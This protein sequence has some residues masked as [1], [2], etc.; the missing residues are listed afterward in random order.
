MSDWHTS[1]GLNISTV[2][3]R[4]SFYGVSGVPHVRIDGLYSVVGAGSCVSA[5]AEYRSRVNSRLSATGGMA[6]V[7]IEGYHSIG[8]TTLTMSV[9]ATLD[10]AVT[11]QSPRMYLVILEDNVLHQGVTYQHIVR[12]EYHEDITLPAQGSVDTITHDFTLGAGWN[13]HNLEC[14]A[15]VQKMTGDKEMYNAARIPMP[16]DFEFALEAPLVSVPQ[17]NGT[18][19]FTG[20][21]TNVSAESDQLTLSLDNTFNW[22]A[23]FMVEGEAGYHTTPSVVDLDSEEGVLVHVRVQT[24]AE[25]RIGQANLVI[26]SSLTDRTQYALLRVFNGSPAILLVDDDNG[27]QPTH[28]TFIDGLNAAGYLYDTWD[29][30]NLHANIT[31]MTEEMAPYDLV[32]WITGWETYEPI[33]AADAVKIMGYMDLGKGFIISGQDLLSSFTAGNTFLVDYLGIGTFTTQIGATQANGVAGDP[34]SAGLGLTLQYPSQSINRADEVIANAIGTTIFTNQTGRPVAVRADNGTARS[35]TLAFAGTAIVANPNPNNCATLLDRSIEWIMAGQGQGVEEHPIALASHIGGINP[36]PLSFR[37]GHGEAAIQLRLSEQAMRS[38]VR[39][40]ILDL[41]GRLVSNVLNG[42][43]P[44]G[45][46]AAAW[47]GLDAS[48]RPVGSGVY[49]ARLTTSDGTHS[50]RMVITR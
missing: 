11:L 1:G 39:V 45:Q 23:E 12:A 22:P 35:V 37:G 6:P 46:T 5:A 4:T 44:S 38:P 41:N 20:Q 40:D 19:Q 3:Q 7:E 24:N 25:V 31:P 21:L 29:V 18:A 16:L 48:G 9:T 13:V 17:G 28:Q 14:V 30:K 47:N 42:T 26:H 36:N 27:I 10:D 15:F 43:L 49:Y 2:S 50:A 33:T 32:L 34:I 8:T